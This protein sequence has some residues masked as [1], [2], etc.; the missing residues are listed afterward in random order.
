[1]SAREVVQCDDCGVG[2]LDPE[3]DVCGDRRRNRGKEFRL[4][5]MQPP[6]P[7]W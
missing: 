5:D 1:M 2:G 3:D 4:F 7:Y 6:G